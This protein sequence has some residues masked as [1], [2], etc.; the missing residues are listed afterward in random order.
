[1]IINCTGYGARSLWRDET[2]VPVRGQIAWLVPQPEVGYGVY[3]DGVGTV[4]RRDGLVVQNS[5]PD[6][7]YGYGNADETPDRAE[8]EAAVSTIARLFPARS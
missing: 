6:E 4:S 7:S 1:V 8:A 2:L 3:Y 5:G